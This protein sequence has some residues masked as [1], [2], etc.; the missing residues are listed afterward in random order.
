M[1]LIFNP[2]GEFRRSPEGPVSQIHS[3]HL[4]AGAPRI[5]SDLL[6]SVQMLKR[7]LAGESNGKRPHPF[8]PS[9]TANLVL[10]FCD[11]RSAFGQNK[12]DARVCTERSALGQN[13]LMM[14]MT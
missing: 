8:I 3:P 10:K 11:G 14:I 9:K 2:L 6:S 13:T 5:F 12:L 7:E 1:E 4:H